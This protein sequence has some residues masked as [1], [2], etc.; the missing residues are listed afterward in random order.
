MATT[1]GVTVDDLQKAELAIKRAEGRVATKRK[2]L[3]E[4]EAG[5]VKARESHAEI[6]RT[7]QEQHCAENGR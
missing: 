6:V 5:L 7:Y 2:H 1:K 4:E 3:V